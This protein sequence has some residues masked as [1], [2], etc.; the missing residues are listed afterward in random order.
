MN[1][2]KLDEIVG[3]LLARPKGLLA[4]DESIESCNKRFEALGVETTEEARREYRELLIT[5]PGI[6]EY[7][8]GFILYDETIRQSTTDG[9]RF[10]DVLKDKGIQVGIKVDQGLEDSGSGEKVTKGLDGLAGRLVEYRAQFSAT[11]TKW[12]SVVVI[13]ENSPSEE[14]MRQNAERFAAYAKTVQ[15]ADMVPIIEPE[16][17]LDGDHS[18]EKCYEVTAKNLDIL[19][20][21]LA[22]NKVYLPGIILKTSM[23]ITGK[24]TSPHASVDAVANMTIKCLREHVPTSLGGIVFLSG[25][26]D[27]EHATLHLNR[28]HELHPQLPWPLTFSYSRAIQNDTLHAW[29]SNRSDIAGA[30]ELLLA[31]TKK[32]SLASIGEYKK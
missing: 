3:A 31:W 12:R 16:V 18:L 9:K 25:G 20:G 13:G 22:E 26:Q 15:E 14:N 1:T 29:A 19:F 8:S 6:E 24:D 11:F 5:T 27:S 10:A 4:I 17:L 28:M 30:Q 23:V 2:R 21:V 7:I 32:D